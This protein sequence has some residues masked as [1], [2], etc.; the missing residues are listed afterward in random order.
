MFVSDTYRLIYFEIPRTGSRSISKALAVLDP[1][2]TTAI[3]RQQDK[4]ADYHRFS[5]PEQAINYPIIATH[6][7]PYDR[8]WSFWKYRNQYG[9]PDIFKQTSWPDYLAWAVDPASQPDLGE[10]MTDIPISEMVNTDLVTHW[11][12]FTNLADD[13]MALCEESNLPPHELPHVNHS[14]AAGSFQ[15]AYNQRCASAVYQRFKADFERFGYREDSW[16]PPAAIAN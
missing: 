3:Q 14:R 1:S 2:S 13:W 12:R 5:V 15:S 11:L 9:N 8:L 7:N 10:A 16:L 6:R 4:A